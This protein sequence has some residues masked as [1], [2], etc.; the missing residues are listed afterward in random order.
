MDVLFEFLISVSK[1]RGSGRGG[2]PIG[3][4][5]EAGDDGKRWLSDGR[6]FEFLI[7][8]SK[9]RGLGRGACPIGRDRPGF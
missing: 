3:R 2:C 9:G 7:S 4:E 1:G 6:S 8:V 5:A